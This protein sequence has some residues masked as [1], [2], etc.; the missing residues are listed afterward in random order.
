MYNMLLVV[1][2]LL[3]TPNDAA[4]S[5]TTYV[6]KF[7]TKDECTAGIRNFNPSTDLRLVYGAAEGG[8]ARFVL[9]CVPGK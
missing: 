5:Q 7:D 2:V 6:G 3:A 9:I 8:Q 4:A 1:Y